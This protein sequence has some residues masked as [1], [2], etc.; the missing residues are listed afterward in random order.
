MK[1]LKNL[2]G[3]QSKI[4]ADSI[5]FESGSNDD[6]HWIRYP[7]GTLECYKYIHS[8]TLSTSASTENGIQ[9]Y[10]A[11][12]PW[13]FPIPFSSSQIH[14]NLNGMLVGSGGASILFYSNR[15]YSLSNLLVGLQ[16]VS[17]SNFV[18]AEYVGLHAI[19]RWK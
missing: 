19:G 8:Q 5:H 16:F 2:L 10:R 13:D 18:R 9:T 6:G 3:D 12:I 17:I 11:A 14:V 4:H 15:I 7:D 1:I